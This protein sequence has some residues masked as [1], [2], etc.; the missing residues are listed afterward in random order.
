MAVIHRNENKP[1][2]AI[3]V[4]RPARLMEEMANVGIDD[5]NSDD[6]DEAMVI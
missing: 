4:G 6:D 1:A 2:S 5:N 3:S